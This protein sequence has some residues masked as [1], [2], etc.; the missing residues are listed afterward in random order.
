VLQTFLRVTEVSK[1]YKIPVHGKTFAAQ[2]LGV[3]KTKIRQVTPL[4]RYLVQR[5]NCFFDLSPK[6]IPTLLVLDST[7]Y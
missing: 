6:P 1:S 2:I 7:K 3:P 4:K 5:K